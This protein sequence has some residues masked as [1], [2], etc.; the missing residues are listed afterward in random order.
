MRIYL[1][2]VVVPAVLKTMVHAGRVLMMAEMILGYCAHDP[3]AFGI[4]HPR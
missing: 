1:D 3:F 2:Y 4:F